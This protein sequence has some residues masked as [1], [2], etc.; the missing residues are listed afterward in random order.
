MYLG[1]CIHILRSLFFVKSCHL[2]SFFPLRSLPPC[3]L[4]GR[5]PHRL[6]SLAKHV[7]NMS[8]RPATSSR[9]PNWHPGQTHALG[10]SSCAKKKRKRQRKEGKNKKIFTALFLIHK[11]FST[12][13]CHY[14]FGAINFIGQDT[15]QVIFCSFYHRTFFD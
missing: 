4:A 13:K 8:R 15:L 7:Y 6:T 2:C 9:N 12:P 5:R 11:D 14:H 1:A 3:S 10:G